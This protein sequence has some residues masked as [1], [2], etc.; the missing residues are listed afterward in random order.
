[1][2]NLKIRLSDYFSVVVYCVSFDFKISEESKKDVIS[3][4]TDF[5][6]KAAFENIFGEKGDVI[7]IN[8]KFILEDGR[9]VTLLLDFKRAEVIYCFNQRRELD[10]I[11]ITGL[12]VK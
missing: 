3:S 5:L 4:I 1:M 9:E 10:K 11:M 2:K 8:Y 12:R 7:Q 6:A